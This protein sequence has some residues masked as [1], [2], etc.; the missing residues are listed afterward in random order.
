VDAYVY[1]QVQPGAVRDVMMQLPAKQGV[2]R[3]VTVVGEWDVMALVEGA[4][5]AQVANV[6]LSQLHQI[7][8][9]VRTL[10]APVVPPDRIGITGGAFASPATPVP[11]ADA[12]YV[13]IRAQAGAVEGLVERL[14]EVDD[15][16]GYAVLGGEYDLL[17]AIPH[18]WEVAS[19]IIIDRILTL[20]GV[21]STTTLVAVSVVESEEDR[22][23]FSSW[24]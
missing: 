16:S 8:G 24:S 1:L 10:T 22:D 6:V 3:A 7:E 14:S 13:H 20:P 11:I 15:V 19:G 5:F 23:Q 21:V 17:V 18:P 9:V 2:R 4:D 12:C